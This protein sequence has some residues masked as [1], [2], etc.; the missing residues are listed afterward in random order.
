[1]SRGLRPDSNTTPSREGRGRRVLLLV[2][3]GIAA[4][5]AC[6]VVRRLVDAGCE[7]RVAMT[8]SAQ[9]FVGRVTFEA[10]SGQAVGTSL[11]GDGGEEPLDHI[12]WAQGIDLLLVAPATLNFLGKMAHG[13]ADDLPSTLVTATDAAIMVAPAMN[14]RM[15]GSEANQQNLRTLAGRGVEIIDPGSGYLACGTVAE[16]RLAEPEAISDRVLERI[17]G[18]PLKGKTILV[19]AGGTREPIDA[20]RW[21]GNHSSGRMGLAVA[22]AA[23]EMGADVRLLLGPTELEPPADIQSA[24]FT[25]T[26]ELRQLLGVHAPDADAIVMSAAVSDWKPTGASDAKLKKTDGIPSLELEPTP[27]LI[28]GLAQQKPAGQFLVGFALES[29]DDQTVEQQARAKLEGKRLDLVCGN[30]ADVGDEGFGSDTNR[31]YLYD[32][33][34][35]G[36]WTPRLT[37]AELGRVILEHALEVAADESSAESAS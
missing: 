17:D 36:H 31:L 35:E 2:T 6:T 23:R 19:T 5:K 20:V 32:R 37:K 11:W 24:R 13:L 9:K 1:M 34:G 21:L 15:W 26:E 29:G 14:D 33:R 28:A 8:D 25:T 27:D 12:Q 10:L 30:R 4:Y 16:G 7:V 18:G 3:G 22:K